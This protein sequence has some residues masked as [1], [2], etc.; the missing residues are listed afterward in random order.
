MQHRPYR[1]RALIGAGV[2]CLAL[3][4]ANFPALALIDNATLVSQTIAYGAHIMP[5]TVVT[6]SWTLK[7]VGSANWTPGPNGYTLNMVGSDSLGAIPTFTNAIT[8]WYTPSAIIASGQT[9]VSN[10]QATFRMMFV[11]PE[12]PGTYTDNFQLNGSTNFG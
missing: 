12:A 4:T 10:D 2:F 3:L 6:Q 8:K 5:R 11:M 7:N 9:V 1:I